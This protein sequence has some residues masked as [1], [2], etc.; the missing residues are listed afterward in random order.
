MR[1]VAA[2]RGPPQPPVVEC[3]VP[4]LGT[5]RGQGGERGVLPHS[6][7]P[8]AAEATNVTELEDSSVVE[9]PP[10]ADVRVEL[11]WAKSQHPGHPEVDDELAVVIQREQQV[12][13]APPDGVD[14]G[15]R[16]ERCGRELGGRVPP[17][18]RDGSTG[19]EWLELPSHRL[20]LGQLR[21][22]CS[23]PVRRRIAT[24]PHRVGSREAKDPSG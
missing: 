24:R 16:R 17:R 8:D 7:H 1:G 20:D 2:L 11:P 13:P 18:L 19:H 3:G 4:R 14:A 5:L 15:P 21:H 23:V 10:G 9:R 22:G 6:D 12:L